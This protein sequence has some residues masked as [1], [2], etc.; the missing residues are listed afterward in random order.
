MN[1]SEKTGG[2]VPTRQLGYV[3]AAL[4]VFIALPR[5]CVGQPAFPRNGRVAVTSV[6]PT[7][8]SGVSRWV[9]GSHI[10]VKMMVSPVGTVHA[11]D[12]SNWSLT[13][14]KEF[15]SY[16]REM[17]NVGTQAKEINK[18]SLRLFA[19]AARAAARQWKFAPS[20][21]E[22]AEEVAFAFGA[23]RFGAFRAIL[24]SF[25]VSWMDAVWYS[26]SA[27][28]GTVMPPRR[29]EDTRPFDPRAGNQRE[30]PE[31]VVVELQVRRDGSVG[32][33]RVMRSVPMLDHYALE[34]ALGWK[35]DAVPVEF[36]MTVPVEFKP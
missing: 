36:V 2:C 26:R 5:I 10:T 27:R 33:A 23:S 31:T 3:A 4:W 11:V 9:S 32:S 34:A 17:G 20:N 8:P 15:A 25:V 30:I 16:P 1:L 7:Y 28:A 14:A 35:Y 19:A 12:I 22:S 6:N 24:P 13:Y 29:I 21:A 18:A